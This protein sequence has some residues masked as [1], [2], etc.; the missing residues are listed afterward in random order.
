MRAYPG[1]SYGKAVDTRRGLTTT[2]AVTDAALA[3]LAVVSI[4]TVTPLIDPSSADRPLDALAYLT[5]VAAGAALAGRRRWPLGVVAV[6]TGAL[7]LYLARGYP[8]G[9]VF[10]CLF[11]ALFSVAMTRSRLVAFS[12]AAAAAGSLVII[13]EVAGTGPGLVHLVFIGW[14]AAAVFLGDAVRSHRG[15]LTALE[16]RAVQLEQSREGE[17]RRRVAEERLRIAQDLHDSVAHSMAIINVQA[18]VGAHLFDRDPTRARDA[19][20]IIHQ[21]SSEVLDELAA[22]LRLLRLGGDQPAPTAPTPGPSQLPSLVESVRRSGLAVALTVEGEL[23]GVPQP[24]GLAM[25]R[26][27]QESLTNVVRHA[28]PGANATVVVAGDRAGGLT[29]EVTDDGIGSNCATPGAGVGLLGMRER[30]AATGGA[31]RAGPRPEGGF[32]VTAAWPAGR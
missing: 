9:P 24:V 4:V 26:I 5:M 19:L 3:G 27:V 12:T 21:T 31:V 13:G 25:Y 6:V 20:G 23:D 28:G 14:T 30:A 7:G 2:R 10:V 11:V 16:E 18:G 29:V 17:A 32:G 22:V 1:R 8:G 15:H